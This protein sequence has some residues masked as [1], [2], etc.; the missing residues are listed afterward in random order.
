LLSMSAATGE[1][2]DAVLEKLW[3][4]LARR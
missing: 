1:G 3:S 2:L 4:F